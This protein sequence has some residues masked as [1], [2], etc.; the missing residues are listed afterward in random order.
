MVVSWFWGKK[1]IHFLH[2]FVT[3]A[4]SCQH[5]GLVRDLTGCCMI[6]SHGLTQICSGLRLSETRVRKLI[7][8]FKQELIQWMATGTLVGSFHPT[9]ILREE[10]VCVFKKPWALQNPSQ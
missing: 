8:F 6:K 9:G 10:D 7:I 2:S 1:T 5:K 4:V 3:K